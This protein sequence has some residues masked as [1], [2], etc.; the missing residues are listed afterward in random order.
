[1]MSQSGKQRIAI[2]ILTNISG[3]K[4]NQTIKFGQLIEY[5][6]KNIFIKKSYKECDEINGLKKSYRVFLIVYQIE[7]Y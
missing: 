7:G 2:H 4:S 5:N 1:M 3:S 6:T